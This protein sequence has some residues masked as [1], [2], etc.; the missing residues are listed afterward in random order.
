MK[1]GNKLQKL[2]CSGFCFVYKFAFFWQLSDYNK[3]TAIGQPETRSQPDV[4]KVFILPFGWSSRKL[5]N[6]QRFIGNAKEVYTR[7][8]RD[9]VKNIDLVQG[10]VNMPVVLIEQIVLKNKK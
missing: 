10:N 9:E 1:T 4:C 8:V 6:K 7:K 5:G 3:A 2:G